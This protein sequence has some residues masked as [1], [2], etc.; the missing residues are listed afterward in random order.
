MRTANLAGRLV[1][2]TDDGA[3]DVATASGGRLPSDPQAVYERWDDLVEWASEATGQIDPLAEAD[4][5]PPAPR[6]RQVFAIGMNYA[7]HASEAGIDLPE[8]PSTFTKFP[9]SV[10]PPYATVS[11]PSG[12]VDWEVELV[13]VIGRLAHHVAEADGWSHVA[14]LTVGQDL[15]ERK[16]QLRPPVPQFSLGKSY[17]GFG[18][19]G[20]LLVTPDELADPDDLG[21]SCTLNG[22][23]MQRARTS[24]LMFPVPA[25][26]SRLSSIV[27]LLPGD[28][29]FTGTPAGI[30]ASRTPPQYLAPGDELRSTVEGVGTIETHFRSAPASVTAASAAAPSAAPS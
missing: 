5:G 13:V 3:M 24:E 9:T 16:V 6:P 1:L 4:L 12:N 26:V 2:V 30:G 11:L 7:A 21:I 27:P 28:L 22:E 25:L 20:P 17:P 29:I 14:G 8:F 23:E 15:S 18:P 10:A 19:T